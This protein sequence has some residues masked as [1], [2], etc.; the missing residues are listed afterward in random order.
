MA[1]WG[2]GVCKLPSNLSHSVIPALHMDEECAGLLAMPWKR[3]AL[4]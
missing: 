2:W 4:D 1:G 3:Q